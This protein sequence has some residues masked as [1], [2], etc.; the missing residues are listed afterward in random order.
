MKSEIEIDESLRKARHNLTVRLALRTII[1][2]RPRLFPSTWNETRWE[3][4]ASTHQGIIDTMRKLIANEIT[5]TGEA[6]HE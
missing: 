4:F 2:D 6:S 3:V 1:F 5:D